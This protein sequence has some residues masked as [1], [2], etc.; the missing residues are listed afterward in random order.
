MKLA[1][2]AA[3]FVLV[4]LVAIASM[5]IFKNKNNNISFG[6]NAITNPLAEQKS[7]E[8]LTYA[9]E[10]RTYSAQFRQI[11]EALE[12]QTRRNA[13]EKARMQAE[14]DRL[15]LEQSRNDKTREQAQLNTQ[16]QQ[17]ENQN[18][19]IDQQNTELKAQLGN[20][21]NRLQELMSNAGN[22]IQEFDSSKVE[23][24]VNDKVSALEQK[25]VD[26]TSQLSQRAEK[27][28]SS[29]NTDDNPF[30][31][32]TTSSITEAIRPSTGTDNEANVEQV[33]RPERTHFSPYGLGVISSKG[34]NN[35]F[36]SFGG[37]NLLPDL[38][39]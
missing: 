5:V 14:I 35:P 31:T 1:K 17:L 27:P 36:S 25:I 22:K 10:V 13:E 12:E 34:S 38:L 19:A 2:V 11:K 3:L 21:E 20:L 7:A 24:A 29:I 32:A 33:E 8:D 6:N 23:A 16:I 39:E 28:I 4:I 37:G 9:Q 26:L 15:K 18:K 30:T